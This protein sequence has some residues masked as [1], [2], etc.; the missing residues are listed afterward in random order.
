MP[1][2]PSRRQQHT[3]SGSIA[4]TLFTPS[5]LKPASPKP[6]TKKSKLTTM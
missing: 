3:H 6:S 2:I 5:S 1:R 4:R